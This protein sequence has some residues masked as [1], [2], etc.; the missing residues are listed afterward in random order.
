MELED[1][2]EIFMLKSM[3]T[4]LALVFIVKE[5]NYDRPYLIEQNLE[6]FKKSLAELLNI[7]NSNLK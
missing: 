5:S 7:T 1:E 3:E 2:N 6:V 4:Y